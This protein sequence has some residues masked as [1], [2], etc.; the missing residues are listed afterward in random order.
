M[1][2]WRFLT[3]AS[4]ATLA[5]LSGVLAADTCAMCATWNAP[6]APFKLYGNAYYVGPHG[7][8]SV[9]V[10]SDRGHIL[11]DGALPESAPQIAAHIK[12]LGF[13]LEDVKV[14]LNSD[15]HFDY[16]GGIAALQKLTG[17]VVKASLSSAAVLQSGGTGDDDPQHTTL[18]PIAPI[19]HVDTVKDGE[20]VRV[21]PLALTAHYTPGHTPGGTTWTWDSCEGNRCL[22]MVYADSLNAVSAPDFFFTRSTTYPHV[23]KDFER[24]FAAVSALPCDILVSVHPE[25]SD[26]WGRLERRDKGDADGL[27]NTEACR[28]YTAST[29]KAFDARVAKEKAN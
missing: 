15:V 18:A 28:Q 7:V 10:T 3:F 20:T 1:K 29:R 25:F 17:A 5:A 26:L 14:I 12:D 13:R 8:G 4:A 6:Q 23:L 2:M 11:I 24:S 19:P 9:L 16:A 21:G 22:H 27:V